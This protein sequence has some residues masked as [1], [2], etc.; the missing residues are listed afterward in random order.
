MST[1]IVAFV[2]LIMLF[3]VG[4]CVE[5]SKSSAGDVSEDWQLG[6]QVYTFRK[7]TIYETIDKLEA[8]GIGYMEG[9]SIHSLSRENPNVK[10]THDMPVEIRAEIKKKLKQAGIKL[11]TYYIV[12]MGDT[13][14][15]C[16][17]VFE[18]AKDMG[19]EVLVSEPPEENIDMIE[20]LCK[21]YKI[22]LA[23][24]NHPKSPPG[25]KRQSRYWNYEKVLEVCKGRSQWIGSCSDT[26]HWARSGLNPI[27]GLKK[28]EG[29]I[30]C[31]HIKDLNEFGVR[32]AHDVPWGTG[33]CD[34]RGMLKEL[35]R[36]NFKG[37][38]SIEYEHNPENPTPEVKKC[39]EFFDE[40][41]SELG[42]PRK[43]RI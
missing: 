25:A 36:Q 38:I 2:L 13:P 16:R 3:S 6:T 39:I 32:E 28:L 23:I 8:L 26:G 30:I 40:V 33:V 43:K 24:H 35:D 37:V 34:A 22:K 15:K 10:T 19:V 14:E 7:F 20:K 17:K 1:R 11:K 42:H 31:L 18:F 4:C 21:E 27:E 12:N 41:A 9:S 29:Q 5:S